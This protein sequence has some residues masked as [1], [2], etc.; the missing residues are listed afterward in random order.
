[1][2]VIAVVI[3]EVFIGCGKKTSSVTAEGEGEQKVNPAGVFPAVNGDP[4]V[5]S[6][7]IVQYPQVSDL[8]NNVFTKMLEDKLN[9]KLNLVVASSDSINEKRNLLLST[10]DY[11]DIFINSAGS[12]SDL[13][14][15][16]TKEKI[17]IPLEPYINNY[18]LNIARK[19][20]DEPGYREG[21]TL[22][23]G[24]IYSIGHV[25]FLMH[26]ASRVKLWINTAWLKKLGLEIPATVEEFKDVLIAFRDS[27]PNG[28]GKKDE[29]PF[30]GDKNPEAEPWKFII[31]CFGYYADSASVGGLIKL[32]NREI[33]P[34]AD[35]AYVR[36][37]IR[38]ARE[39]YRE[40]LI[41]PG[42]FTQDQA[43]L[44]QLGAADPP[45]MGAYTSSH[46]ARGVDVSKVDI[47]TQYDLLMPLRGTNGYYGTPL[48]MTPTYNGGEFAITDKCKYPEAAMRLIDYLFEDDVGMTARWGPKGVAWAPPDPG[49]LNSSGMPA[50]YKAL[51]GMDTQGILAPRNDYWASAAIG[52]GYR[53]VDVQFDGDLRAPESYEAY[54]WVV[55]Q[56]YFKV[57][58]PY[59]QIMP[60]ELTEDDLAELTNQIVTIRD[61]VRSAIVQFITGVRDIE[62]D[63]DTYKADLIRLHYH[64]YV[65]KFADLYLSQY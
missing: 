44:A 39:L 48:N 27:D 57:G 24:H 54:L 21:M 63:W 30:S 17:F 5:M 9:I 32:Q 11:P 13:R 35:Q 50:T 34:V 45:I 46:L 23:D 49:A 43:Q 4:V 26:T 19:L 58:C 1:M 38:F 56:G 22:E 25:Q 10:G 18:A 59:E 47:A 7:F 28:N 15:Y 14:I 41:D 16:G 33:T 12:R 51:S 36:D 65:K 6:A 40:G 31:N 61:Y 29:I 60:L 62:T 52:G 8:V 64:D 53:N 2:V 3:A 37:G 42:S 55:S 20:R